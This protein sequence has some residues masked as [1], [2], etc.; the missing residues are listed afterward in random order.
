ME[1]GNKKLNIE[2]LI[3]NEDFS[4]KM[5]TIRKNGLFLSDEEIEILERYH[6]SYQ[7]CSNPMQLVSMIDE[8][9]DMEEIPE[10][11]QIAAN[12]AEQSYYQ[13]TKK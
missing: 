6:I 8:V 4:K 9:L 11:D 13:N 5:H 2:D 1:V 10:L 3:K 12:I 7:A